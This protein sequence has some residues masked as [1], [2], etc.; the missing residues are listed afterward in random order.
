MLMKQS[1]YN[2]LACSIM[3]EWPS[4]ALPCLFLTRY[5]LENLVYLRSR[6]AKILASIYV[7]CSNHFFIVWHSFYKYF[8]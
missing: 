7:L 4:A 5:C 1:V 3:C 8:F 6:K 2:Y